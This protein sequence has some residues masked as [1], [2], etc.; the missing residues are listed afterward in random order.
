MPAA[1]AVRFPLRGHAL[2]VEGGSCVAGVAATFLQRQPLDLACA[3]ADRISLPWTGYLDQIW[4][5]RITAHFRSLTHFRK[6]TVQFV[7]MPI[8]TKFTS[9]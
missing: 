9:Y 2:P 5:A 1:T 6:W 8:V 4:K 7:V 3:F